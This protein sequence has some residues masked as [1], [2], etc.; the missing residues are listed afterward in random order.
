MEERNRY[1][2]TFIKVLEGLEGVRK[3]PSMYIGSTDASGLHHLV[4][5]VVDNSIDEA[6]AGFC[7]NI[8]VTI[9]KDNSISVLDDGRGIPP[10]IHPQYGVSG[11]ELAL[12]KLHAGGKFEGKAYKVS[13]GLHGVGISVVNALSEDLY[14]EVYRD[15][16][17]YYQFYSKG[18]SL[19]ELKEE[20]IDENKTGT[21]IKFKPDPEI[22]ETTEFNYEIIK[23]RLI[24]LAF[25]NKGVRIKLVDERTNKVEEFLYDGGIKSYFDE[26]IKDKD[27]THLPIY[28]SEEKENFFF[29]VIFTYTNTTKT[30]ILSY[31]NSIYTSE[32]GTHLTGFRSGLTKFLNEEGKKFEFL[33]NDD[34]FTWEDVAE[35]LF[36]IINIRIFDPQFEGQTKTKLGNSWVKKEFE[37][38]I[39]HNLI[40]TLEKNPNTL[41]IILKRVELSKK[42][43]EA[44]RKARELVRKKVFFDETLP[45]KLADC[46]EKD[47][48]KSELFIVEGESAG[49]SAK[50]GRNR[51]TQAILPLRGKILNAIKS[52]VHKILDN[53]EIKSI[54]AS[55]G[56]GILENFDINKLRYKKII[57]M[58]DAD[59]D[60]SHIKTLLLAFFWT[61]LKEIIEEGYLY[62]AMPPLYKISYGK[63][64]K[65]A[66][67]EEEKDK[68]IGELEKG[69][70]K[71]SINRY[72]GL[73]EMN[74]E[75]LYETTMNPETR[76]LKK[77]QV[78]DGERAKEIIDTLMGEDVL[79]RKNFIEEHALEVKELDI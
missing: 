22:F 2:A 71:Y 14:V 44:A 48:E 74:P 64:K 72:K 39:Y 67:S 60:G 78:Q 6:M 51:T 31:V 77:V 45:G 36:A 61:Y 18:K 3:R 25:L 30:N 73:G 58:T 35:G 24:T 62:V 65:Y 38:F 20:N 79:I 21:F 56:T 32:G 43:R 57:I 9:H 19:G 68:I 55:L 50:Q 23:E 75:E 27:L 46:S 33:K 17:K 28:F 66:Y 52:S 49:G 5:E 63:N 4:F 8:I 29:E 53:N 47:P 40:S 69:G 41:K 26:L 13:G 34:S 15:G 54:I 1:D 11:I 59:V 76:I 10:D 37:D 16:K 7:K 70:I 12:T 42:A